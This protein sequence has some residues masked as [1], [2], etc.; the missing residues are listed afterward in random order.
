[1]DYRG[2]FNQLRNSLKVPAAPVSSLPVQPS[3]QA[4]F[5]QFQPQIIQPTYVPQFS[6]PPP[7]PPQTSVTGILRVHEFV[8]S[9]GKC[10]LIVAVLCL[11]GYWL[12]N[13][14]KTRVT[15]NITEAKFRAETIENMMN[16]NPTKVPLVTTPTP[17]PDPNFTPL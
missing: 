9:W 4:S 15:K 17:T 7:P 2:Q 12:Y 1:M 10:I 13:Y 11:L 3:P 8:K 16:L 5:Q 6:P 14:N